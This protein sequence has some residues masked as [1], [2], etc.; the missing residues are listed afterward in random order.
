MSHPRHVL[1]I[2]QGT[3]S[4]RSIVFDDRGRASPSRGVSTRSTSPRR[5]GSSMMPTPSGATARDHARSDRAGGFGAR[6]SP[7]SASPTSARTDGA[8]GPRRR[9]AD[10]SRHR[11]AGP[12]HGAG[13]RRACKA[14]APKSSSGGAPACCSIRISRAPRSR[15]LLDHVPG[16]RARAERGELAFGTIDSFLLWRLTG[17]RCTR[18]T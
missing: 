2:D 10:P 11:L 5:A 9:Q 16:A 4:T 18:P 3:T 17:G 6:T 14:T 12:A 1:A 15:W 7:P 13:M 8:V